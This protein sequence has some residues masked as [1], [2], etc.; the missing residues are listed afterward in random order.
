MME[1][2]VFQALDLLNG[3]FDWIDEIYTDSISEEESDYEGKTI[4]LITEWLNEP[5]Y[6]A[7]HTFNGWTVGV[8]VQ[9]FYKLDNDI[10]A[11][12]G[13]QA[14]ARLFVDNNWT[15]EKSKN[16]IK[17]PDTKQVTKVFYF[18]KDEII[19]EGN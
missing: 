7:N 18:A 3:K 2:P 19:K 17:D 6:Y 1:L 9:I 4:C 15:V 14:L 5:T 12:D 11:L 8:E 13:E 16:H 10:S